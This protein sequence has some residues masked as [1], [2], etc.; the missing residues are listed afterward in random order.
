MSD[1]QLCDLL[2]EFYEDIHPDLVN[3]VFSAIRAAQS[4]NEFVHRPE[5]FEALRRLILNL[6]NPQQDDSIA[7]N[8]YMAN[9][10]TRGSCTRPFF[11]HMTLRGNLNPDDSPVYL[12]P[13]PSLQLRTSQAITSDEWAEIF[14][15]QPTYSPLPDISEIS[16]PPPLSLQ[17]LSFPL[18][19]LPS[20]FSSFSSIE[21]SSLFPNFQPLPL[22][23]P[24][25]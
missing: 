12:P 17:S 20:S 22:S 13:P 24:T 8:I 9:N 25:F 14:L 4:A 15:S 19:P 11:Y 21:S 2:N 16:L 23:F 1:Q 5:I 10:S 7:I 18:P 6:S 3:S